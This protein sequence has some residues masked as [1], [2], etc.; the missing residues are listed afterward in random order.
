MRRSWKRGLRRSRKRVMRWSWARA[1]RR[2]W[3]RAMTRFWGR[4]MRRYWKRAR[5]WSWHRKMRRSW[6]RTLR[7]S[8]SQ[9]TWW[10]WNRT[11]PRARTKGVR[12][13]SKRLASAG[14]A[15]GALALFATAL[16]APVT[17][18]NRPLWAIKISEPRSSARLSPGAAE[19]LPFTATT[20]SRATRT[21][22]RFAASIPAQPNGDAETMA[23]ADIPGCLARWFTATVAEVVERAGGYDGA[24]VLTMRNS[25]TNQDACQDESPAVTVT[26]AG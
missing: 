19:T 25:G 17:R 22:P 16:P 18:A 2:S 4:A 9:A 14:T 6:K 7:R 20:R 23:A 24:V 10:T 21:P 15:I 11:P 12:P 8:G 26:A 1:L 3:S 5:T 13:A